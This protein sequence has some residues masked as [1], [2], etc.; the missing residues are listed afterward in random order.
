MASQQFASRLINGQKGLWEVCVGL[1]IHAQILSASKLFSGAS[2][3]GSKLFDDVESA[4]PGGRGGPNSTVAAFDA[5]H[6]GTMP[7][8]N[9]HCVSQGVRAGMAL[10]GDIQRCNSFVRKHYFYPDLPLGYQITQLE[11]PVVLG[12]HLQFT[13]PLRSEK[14]NARTRDTAP[15]IAGI[16]RIQIEQDSGKSSHTLNRDKSLIDLN[17]AGVGLLEV[18]TMPDLRSADEASSFLRKLQTLL[19]H[20]GVCDGEFES[21][22]IRCDVNVSVR[23][24]EAAYA[25]EVSEVEVK[26][27]TMPTPASASAGRSA[28]TQ[29]TSAGA[30]S[31][32]ARRP[33]WYSDVQSD[34]VP[35]AATLAAPAYVASGSAWRWQ[36]ASNTADSTQQPKPLL[37]ELLAFRRQHM[38]SF[39]ARVEMK[40]LSSIR[41][42]YRG[43]DHEAARQIAILEGTGGGAVG[44]VER[45]TRLFDALLRTSV[46]LR[47]KEGLADYR[48]VF[49]PTTM[50]MMTLVRYQACPVHSLRLLQCLHHRHCLCAAF[51]RFLPEPD[52]SP[53]ILPISFLASTLASMPELPDD[54]AAILT[55]RHGLPPSDAA[56]IVNEPGAIA[57]YRGAL[58]AACTEAA[59]ALHQH[60]AASSAS[61]STARL[62][63]DAAKP[64]ARNV[65]NW[66]INEVFGSLTE[67]GL[68]LPLAHPSSVAASGGSPLNA[69]RADARTCPVDA[70]RF[71][72]LVALVHSGFVSGK[73]GKDV[74]AIMM[75]EPVRS[76]GVAA[77]GAQAVVAA[78]D[79]D[80]TDGVR[81][82][83]SASQFAAPDVRSPKE[84][85]VSKGWA[86]LND[87]EAIMK[88]A[89]AA[90]SDPKFA[91]SVK[92]WRE[93]GQ[94]R[95]AGPIMAHV[96]Q[97]SGG[98]ANPELASECV[99]DVL[100]PLGQRPQPR[101]AKGR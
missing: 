34:E 36:H 83:E 72:Q 54:T 48:C 1:E 20:L 22:S 45:E 64:L 98:L 50:M 75:G 13:T 12:G 62:L 10:R 67:R 66:L 56:T 6:P 31:T 57:Y 43:V 76:A 96:L 21:G 73:R 78:D 85:I 77:K 59:V 42:V 3:S 86:Q 29:S 81:P 8:I 25:K 99:R 70:A 53:I 19:V 65:F 100:G 82:G 51:R 30:G 47:G 80:D 92:K 71:G 18:V 84:I 2:A 16:D 63:S 17:R 46:R 15:R 5:A 37:E 90:V 32:H 91:E 58:D 55:S 9:L 24:V 74:L 7:Q 94:D 41:A 27:M 88:L 23:P 35:G 69:V 44:V 79:D 95:V 26:S 52:L 14:S 89:V 28:Q 60:G 101:G 11:R 87:R 33:L 49:Q 93:L 68:A 40:N 39:G 97:S 61:S 38:P 4:M